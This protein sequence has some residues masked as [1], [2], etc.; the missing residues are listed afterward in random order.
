M[1]VSL[2]TL[3][4]VSLHLR[5]K[6][7]K[8]FFS[9]KVVLND[10]PSATFGNLLFWTVHISSKKCSRGFIASNNTANFLSLSF[11][12]ILSDLHAVNTCFLIVLCQ[13]GVT[14]LTETNKL[15]H[16]IEWRMNSRSWNHYITCN[17]DIVFN[18]CST[19][20]HDILTLLIRI[21][22]IF[23]RPHHILI[24]YTSAKS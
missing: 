4:R 12:N 20:R 10:W 7:H 16:S 21:C 13:Q 22:C 15:R 8:I 6:L 18:N 2:I 9:H 24:S 3:L 11:W 23:I 1:F 19:F 14:Q 5:R 17:I